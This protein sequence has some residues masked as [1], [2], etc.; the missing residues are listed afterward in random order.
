MTALMISTRLVFSRYLWLSTRSGGDEDELL[1][2][3]GR[4]VGNLDVGADELPLLG[5]R[6][7]GRGKEKQLP[8]GHHFLLADVIVV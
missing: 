7:H 5:R 3:V 4:R 2:I 8:L 1:V 6:G